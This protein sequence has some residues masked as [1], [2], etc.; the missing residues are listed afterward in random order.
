[1]IDYP[2]LSFLPPCRQFVCTCCCYAGKFLFLLP[3]NS[4]KNIRNQIDGRTTTFDSLHAT[5]L[6]LFHTYQPFF[7][8]NQSRYLVFRLH[9]SSLFVPSFSLSSCCVLRPPVLAFLFFRSFS[10]RLLRAVRGSPPWIDRRLKRFRLLCSMK[11][12]S[13]I[14][15]GFFGSLLLNN[16]SFIIRWIIIRTRVTIIISSIL[17][18][19][20]KIIRLLEVVHPSGYHY[21]VVP[22]RDIHPLIVFVGNSIFCVPSRSSFLFVALL[23]LQLL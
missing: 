16:Q 18:L 2:I 15:R 20:S 8:M 21:R 13:K 22:F 5:I 11:W 6:F 10:S 3:F 7:R 23:L 19:L 14:L 12:T 17:L 9:S 1:M 4:P